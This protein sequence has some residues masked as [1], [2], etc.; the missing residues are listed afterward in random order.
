M[1]NVEN[2][3]NQSKQRHGCVTAWL[4]LLIIIN[5]LTALSYL[6]AGGL[7]SQNIPGGVSK[8]MMIILALMGIANV[9]F[10]VLL[11][12]WRKIGFWGF[13]L[14]SIVALAI[15]LNIGMSIGQSL[16]GLVGIILL[17]GVLQIKKDQVS[18]WNQLD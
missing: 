4:I 16:L 6:F 2:S 7:I 13:L 14:T 15:N 8:S 11:F 1:Q 18:A 5:S 17:Y 3:S 9:I 12:K 10:A